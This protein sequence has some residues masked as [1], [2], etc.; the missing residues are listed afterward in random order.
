MA[1]L[2]GAQGVATG[3]KF[4]A[5]Y[6]NN[7]KLEKI[8]VEAGRFTGDLLHSVPF[9]PEFFRQEFHSAVAGV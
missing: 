9:A 5:I 7:E 2:T 8:A 6:C 4:G 1:T 3:N